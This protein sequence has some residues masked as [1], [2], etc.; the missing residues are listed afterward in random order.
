M[1]AVKELMVTRLMFVFEMYRGSLCNNLTM[2][3]SA[4]LYIY[5]HTF[6][7]NYPSLNSRFSSVPLSVG[8]RVSLPGSEL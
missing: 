6:P 3:V 7:A 2:N 4:A 1:T 5:H 8:G